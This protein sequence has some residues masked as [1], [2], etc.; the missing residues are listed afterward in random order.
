[1]LA[2]AMCLYNTSDKEDLTNLYATELFGEDQFQDKRDCY[3]VST[4]CLKR[5]DDVVMRRAPTVREAV[6]AQRESTSLCVVLG[7]RVLT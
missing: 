3:R 2:K 1:M 7:R 4:R 6:V 5:P